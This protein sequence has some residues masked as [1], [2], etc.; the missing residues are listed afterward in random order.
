[1]RTIVHLSDLHFGRLDPRV[2]ET[3]IAAID[4]LAPD[5]VAISGDFTQRARIRQFAEARRFLDRLPRPLLV[6]PGNHDIPLYD[7]SRRFLTPLGRYRRFIAAEMEPVFADEELVVVGLNSA[8]SLSFGRGRLSTAQISRTV[9][10]LRGVPPTVIKI[11]VTH[12]PFDLPEHYADEHLVGRA[13]MAMAQL[14]TVGADLF[15]AGHLHVSHISQT[16]ARYKIAG[17]SALVVQAGTLSTRGR[18]EPNS[19]NV[20]GVDWPRIAVVRRTWDGARGLYDAS[21]ARTF[22]HGELGW[23]EK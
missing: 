23:V 21:P 13:K 3:T 8:R 17:H 12:H 14:A 2:V 9:E 18:G 1:M 4:E 22:R 10:R 6:V 19:F 15:L 11:I 16:A 5:L 20:L 7:V